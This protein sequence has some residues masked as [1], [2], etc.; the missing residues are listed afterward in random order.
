MAIIK[1]T[2]V[3]DLAGN[4]VQDLGEVPLRT[5][6]EILGQIP[7]AQFDANTQYAPYSVNVPAASRVIVRIPHGLS[8]GTNLRRPDITIP[9]K[10]AN[11]NDAATDNF[12]VRLLVDG[13]LA[14]SPTGMPADGTYVYL[15]LF[16]F[17]QAQLSAK[18]VVYI[19]YTHS[20]IT[21]EV[22]TGTAGNITP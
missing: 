22:V 2:D 13:T 19:E 21:S 5:Y 11:V 17:T 8:Q 7:P 4:P 1:Q 3:L 15:A 14:V 18:F 10:V 9:V 20:M 6:R 16:N 12:D